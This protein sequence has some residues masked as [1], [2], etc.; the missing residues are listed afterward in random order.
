MKTMLFNPYSGLPRH[1]SDIASDPQGMLML[2]PDEPFLAAPNPP[3]SQHSRVRRLFQNEKE[4]RDN[5][6]YLKGQE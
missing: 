5:N 3:M 4:A 2:D 1:P 6:W